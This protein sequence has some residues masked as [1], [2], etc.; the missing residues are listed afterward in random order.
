M[1]E[2][3]T[4]LR[5]FPWRRSDN[6]SLARGDVHVNLIHITRYV[7]RNLDLE[8]NCSLIGCHCAGGLR[9]RT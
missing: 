3:L 2:Y 1:F 8:R 4:R 5:R 7:V 6:F 9:I